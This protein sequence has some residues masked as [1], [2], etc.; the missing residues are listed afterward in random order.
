MKA[1]KKTISSRK[2]TRVSEMHG[3]STI[4]TF[5]KKVGGHLD[6]VGAVMHGHHLYF[7]VCSDNN[8]SQAFRVDMTTL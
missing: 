8:Q 7:Q 1:K 2:F 5:D 3:S 6:L 4:A